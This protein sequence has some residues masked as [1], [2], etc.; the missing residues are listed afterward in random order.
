M[1][2]IMKP[3]HYYCD[4]AIL[5]GAF[6]DETMDMTKN[7]VMIHKTVKNLAKTDMVTCRP[8]GRMIMVTTKSDPATKRLLKVTEVHGKPASFTLHRQLNFTTGCIPIPRD[9][10]DPK[11][12]TAE[13]TDQLVVSHHSYVNKSGNKKLILK[14]ARLTLPETIYLDHRAIKVEP[15]HQRPL[16]CSKCQRFGHHLQ[17]C[18]APTRCAYC[19]GGHDLDNCQNRKP[20]CANCRGDHPASD[21]GCPTWKSEQEAICLSSDKK[22]LKKPKTLGTSSP[23]KGKA[24]PSASLSQKSGAAG[25]N[26]AS[27]GPMGSSYA[28]T[29]PWTNPRQRVA[30]GPSLSP[31]SAPASSIL[32]L[33]LRSPG[34]LLRVRRR[35]PTTPI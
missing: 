7:P 12:L 29:S 35:K 18:K 13:L 25:A 30:G 9:F 32:P 5:V 21:L 31:P 14:F 3:D 26:P 20:L 19:A 23:P 4:G 16:R 34:P 1:E 22:L 24:K 27:D 28:P 6:K 15:Y 17:K 10:P 33:T 2:I 8:F 11:T